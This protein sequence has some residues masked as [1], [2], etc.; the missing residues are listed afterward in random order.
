MSEGARSG[1]L[2]HTATKTVPTGTAETIIAA[3]DNQRRAPNGVMVKSLSTNTVLV[4]VG[5]SDVTTSNGYPLSAGEYVT[6][7]VADPSLVYCISG[8]SSQV[9]RFIY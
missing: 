3:A 1:S 9:L 5:G 8:S 4:Y 2:L 7:P 6:L